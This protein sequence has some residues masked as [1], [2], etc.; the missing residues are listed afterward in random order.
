MPAPAADQPTGPAVAFCTAQCAA[1]Y[2]EAIGDGSDDPMGQATAANGA[3][4]YCAAARPAD[5]GLW[6]TVGRPARTAALDE[7]DT[8]REALTHEDRN[9]GALVSIVRDLWDGHPVA[10]V[11]A[12]ADRLLIGDYDA[13]RRIKAIVAALPADA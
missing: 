1:T 3:C 4:S 12:A 13:E 9:T 2:A 7:I 6:V 5:G 10:D 11:K 8:I